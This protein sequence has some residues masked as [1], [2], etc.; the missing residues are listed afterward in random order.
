MPRPR[1]RSRAVTWSRSA[2]GWRRP[3]TSEISASAP[4]RTVRAHHDDEPLSPGFEL[5][6]LATALGRP[7]AQVRA[8]LVGPRDTDRGPG[9]RA[10]SV[11]RRR[12]RPTPSPDVPCSRCSTRLRSRHRRLPTPRSHVCTRARGRAR[13]RS[14][15]SCS[16]PARSR[17]PVR[18]CAP[19]SPS[20]GTLSVGDVRELLGSSRKYV[21]PLLE[22]FDREGFTRR[23]GDVRVAGP[24][25][26]SGLGD[27]L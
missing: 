26:A 25:L 22:Q 23:R 18:S 11:A 8:A 16:P 24:R 27:Q 10:R 17:A 15:A 5:H 21:V 3:T 12:A 1:K 6:A 13:G 19:R 2:T 20:G 14:T 9:R 7:S 4:G